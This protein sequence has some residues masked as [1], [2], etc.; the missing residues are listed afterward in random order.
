M[1]NLVDDPEREARNAVIARA[2]KVERSK[3]KLAKITKAHGYDTLFSPSRCMPEK[4]RFAEKKF[5]IECL[6]LGLHVH[7]QLEAFHGLTP[8]PNPA[9]PMEDTAKAPF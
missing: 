4:T 6:A 3:K 5:V 7:P 2:A 9:A 1:V 8:E